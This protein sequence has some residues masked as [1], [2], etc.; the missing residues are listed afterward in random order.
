MVGEHFQAGQWNQLAHKLYLAYYSF[1]QLSREMNDLVTD[2]TDQQLT[3]VGFSA[4]DITD[5]R[6]G[7]AAAD[8]M[9]RISY[10]L[11]VNQA[12]IDLV[13]QGKALIGK[14]GGP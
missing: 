1:V 13:K 2:T 12:L 8:G 14:F 6:N 5:L 3:D 11:S 7:A 9:R 4:T 10:N